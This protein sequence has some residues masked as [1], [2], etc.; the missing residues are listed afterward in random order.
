M[1]N[2]RLSV[3]RIA[4]AFSVV[5]GILVSGSVVAQIEEIIVTAQK[6]NE[7]LQEIPGTVSA[8][9]AGAMRN[10][11]IRSSTEIA[12][13]IPNFQIMLP[14]GDSQPVFV[15]RGVSM[16]DFSQN[17]TSPIVMYVDEGL[18]GPFAMQGMQLYDLERIE[19]LKGPQGTL[20]GRNATG[21]TVNV[22][23]KKPSFDGLE[24]YLTAG[25]G[26][27]DRY[28][29]NGAVNG[30]LI[31]EKL[32]ARLAFTYA[33]QDGYVRV[34]GAGLNDQSATDEYAVRLSL[35]A[36]PFENFEAS[37]RLHKAEADPIN[38]GGLSVVANPAFGG[39]G[40]SPGNDRTGLG[41]FE[42][43]T[44]FTPK[45]THDNEGVA[46]NVNWDFMDDL[47]LT[48][49]T[50]YD[51]AQYTSRADDDGSPLSITH[52]IFGSDSKQ[53]TQELRLTSSYTGPFNWIAGIFYSYDEIDM[54]GVLE[55]AFEFAPFNP[56][57]PVFGQCDI[58]FFAGCVAANRF[59]QERESLA[60]FIHTT[61]DVTEK[62]T[63]AFGLRYTEDDITVNDYFADVNDPSGNFPI[64]LIPTVT[65]L[66]EDS[67][68]VTGTLSL[69]YK[70]QENIL[71]YFTASRG[72]RIGAFNGL[73]F[74]ATT[75]VNFAQPELVDAFE[76]GFKSEL[77]N[78]RVRLNAAAFMYDYENMQ[79]LN[80][81]PLT[82]T[83]TI[84]N[85]RATSMEGFDLEMLAQVTD[86]ITVNAGLGFLDAKF[87]ELTLSNVDLSGNDVINAPKWMFNIGADYVIP[88]PSTG[89]F[90]LHIDANYTDDQFFDAF[91]DTRVSQDSYWLANARLNW[92]S[93]GDSFSVALWVK[94][95]WEEEYVAFAQNVE[96][97][98][99][100]IFN[101]RGRPREFGA[102]FSYRF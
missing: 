41:F 88:T 55:N 74:F 12:A 66:K 11:K 31:D 62:V 81:D 96:A 27:F 68:E 86:N 13:Q 78:Q 90:S 14:Y 64:T 18:K 65:Q 49:I 101:Q 71:T 102:E 93:P 35:L 43:N 36:R 84:E 97:F 9:T 24:G 21:G 28:E 63:I 1:F 51:E 94:N 8:L 20:Y 39:V 3:C 38:Y 15:A 100:S 53:I 37:L 80:T 87:D 40:F 23:T 25:V 92:D 67:N 45:L 4:V 82:F 10:L 57:D 61:Y 22:I 77:F 5:I 72:Y 73:A 33:E 95:L 42:N 59:N 91:N 46:L 76:I 48:S 98:S 85:A 79:F 47:R 54:V 56:P 2:Y 75:E 99:N 26:R 89:T 19:V 60:G 6:R 29:F 30:T 70:I 16:S 7:S 32:A 34:S 83:L 52:S 17:Q 69:K 58:I 44:N 50:T